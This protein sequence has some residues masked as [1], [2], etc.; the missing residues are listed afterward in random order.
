MRLD[1]LKQGLRENDL[2]ESRDYA[3]EARFAEG[4]YEKRTGGR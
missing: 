3:I 4:N 2:F 1:A